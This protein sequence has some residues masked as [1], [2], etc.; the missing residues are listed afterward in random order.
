MESH[1]NKIHIQK[2]IKKYVNLTDEITISYS[3]AKF[4]T[5]L[6]KSQI[7]TAVHLISFVLCHHYHHASF[8]MMGGVSLSLSSSSQTYVH[9]MIIIDRR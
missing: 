5:R 2:E 4:D 1:Q 9:T 8:S 6:F 3:V 7:Q